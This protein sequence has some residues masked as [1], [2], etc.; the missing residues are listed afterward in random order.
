VDPEA[1]Q[2][3]RQAIAETLPELILEPVADYL[4]PLP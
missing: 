4:A 1:W 2:Q 3:L